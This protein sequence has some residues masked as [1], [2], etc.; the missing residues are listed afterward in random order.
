MQERRILIVDDSRTM[1]RM[2]ATALGGIEH[3]K[4]EHAASGLEAIERLVLAK[5]DLMV[6]DLVSTLRK[7]LNSPAKPGS[8][9]MTAKSIS[10]DCWGRSPRA[11]SQPEIRRTSGRGVGMDVVKRRFG[12]FSWNLGTDILLR[13]LI[14]SA[15]EFFMT[16]TSSRAPGKA[17]SAG[18]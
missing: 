13:D 12:S 16:V 4:F 7:W 9:L 14:Q 15:L 3:C 5:P 10:I 2:I 8:C 17:G 6:L 11:D 1:R 18:N